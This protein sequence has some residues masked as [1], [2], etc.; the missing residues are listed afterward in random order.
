LFLS[1]RRSFWGQDD[2]LCVVEDLLCHREDLLCVEEDCRSLKEDYF[3]AGQSFANPKLVVFGASS[4]L[5]SLLIPL[6]SLLFRETRQLISTNKLYLCF[7]R[8]FKDYFMPMKGSDVKKDLHAGGRLPRIGPISTG[9]HYSRPD[10]AKNMWA[11]R[12]ILRS[13]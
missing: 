13:R 12:G 8:F 10:I 2:L 5:A 7:K 1:L 9:F 11:N 6:A 3:K 4:P